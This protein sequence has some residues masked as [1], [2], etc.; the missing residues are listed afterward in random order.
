LRSPTEAHT[1]LTALSSKSCS[2]R[3]EHCNMKRPLPCDANSACAARPKNSARTAEVKN[4]NS[5]AYLAARAE[6]KSNAKFSVL[7][8]AGKIDQETRL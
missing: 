3:S 2:T 5:F 1:Y 8:L 7:E 6:Y 4:L